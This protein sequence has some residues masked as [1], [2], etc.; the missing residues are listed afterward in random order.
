MNVPLSVQ[1]KASMIRRY[2]EKEMDQEATGPTWDPERRA[3]WVL[4]ELG[5]DIPC[6]EELHEMFGADG[7][8]D[9]DHHKVTLGIRF[10]YTRKN[11]GTWT[12]GGQCRILM[13]G[14]EVNG[15]EFSKV[16]SLMAQS[17]KFGSAN[18]SASSQSA[19]SSVLDT[20]KNTVIRV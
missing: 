12:D 11:H 13:D 10:V 3:W 8:C 16:M 14:V 15:L 17:T 7:A 19:P 5:D 18:Q 9:K 20:K 6:D 4:M 2:W 1:H